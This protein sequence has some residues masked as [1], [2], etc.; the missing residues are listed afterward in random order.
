MKMIEISEDPHIAID[1]DKIESI[2]CKNFTVIVH[3]G[4]SKHDLKFDS[5]QEA[6]S[7]YK[8]LL[9]KINE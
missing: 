1:I 8:Y 7:H 5:L 3:V 9:I 6:L 4:M 2:S